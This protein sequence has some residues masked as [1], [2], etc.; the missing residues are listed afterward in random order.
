[1]KHVGFLSCIAILLTLSLISCKDDDA[2]EPEV[3]FQNTTEEFLVFDYYNEG[4]PTISPTPVD[5]SAN[6]SVGLAEV[7]D[8]GNDAVITLSGIRV[9]SPDYSYL[10]DRFIIDEDDGNGYM[11]Q[12]E[13]GADAS[14]IRTDIA[15]V[16]VLDMS[17]SLEGIIDDLKAYAKEY[18]NAVV[19]SSP[20]SLVAVVFFSSRNAIQATS[21]VNADNIGALETLIDNFN[22]YQNKTALFEA[23]NT[24]INLVGS[25]Y[26]DGEK[27]VVVFTD[28]GDNDSN[29]PSSQ[30][31]TIR[32]SGVN[33]FAIGLKGQD[34]VD[35]D[36]R[37]IASND[38]Q[39][40]VA[41]TEGDLASIFRLV[42]KGVI[43]VYQL[44]YKRSNQLLNA[45]EKIKI[46]VRIE[47][48]RI[49]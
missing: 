26:F 9:Q 44:Q 42:T 37:A 48:S 41:E 31:Q 38:T 18:A 40:V 22:N 5:R 13:F 3:I 19:N 25:L 49:Q 24:A 29:N 28:G 2:F 43:S 8:D 39:Y 46:K 12:F 47:A 34:F 11:N 21:F 33:T 16:L 36:L 4:T 7:Y 14:S 20:N 35:A 23:T 27:S 15:S 45:N 1:M 10:V 17:S 32:N 6:V 30:L